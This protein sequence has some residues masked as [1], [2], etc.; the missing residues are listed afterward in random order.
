MLIFTQLVK[1]LQAFL[2]NLKARYR[3]HNSPDFEDASVKAMPTNY[4]RANL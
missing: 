3:V 4:D 1:K 2:W